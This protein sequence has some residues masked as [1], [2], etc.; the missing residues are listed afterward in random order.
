[1]DLQIETSKIIIN[2]CIGGFDYS[3]MFYKKYKELYGE[4]NL[5]NNLFA[6][7]MD[8]K[9]INVFESLGSIKS[10]SIL[11]D[12]KIY[13]IPKEMIKYVEIKKDK[14][15]E[16]IIINYNKAY[17]VLL[18]NIIDNNELLKVYEE[19]VNRIKYIEKT[20]VLSSNNDI[21]KKKILIKNSNK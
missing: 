19:Q 2:R 11:S 17:R 1:M 9:A 3:T 5:D 15:C 10:S 18:F 21:I 13:Y 8:E 7:R 20:Y 6:S 12:L 16:R 4:Y 14:G